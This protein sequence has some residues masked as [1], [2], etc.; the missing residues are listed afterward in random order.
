MSL[1]KDDNVLSRT[2]CGIVINN[3]IKNLKRNTKVLF[4]SWSQKSFTNKSL[5]KKLCFSVSRKE[6]KVSKSFEWKKLTIK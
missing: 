6:T 5:R 3:E 1:N 2:A 4:E